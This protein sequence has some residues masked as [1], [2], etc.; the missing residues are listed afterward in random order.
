M[1]HLLFPKRYNE[2]KVM[3]ICHSL[4]ILVFYLLTFFTKDIVLPQYF[5][6]TSHCTDTFG[7]QER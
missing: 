7:L 5:S 1:T 3:N 6:C 2:E 4:A